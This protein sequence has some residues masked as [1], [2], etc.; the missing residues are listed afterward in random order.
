[1]LLRVVRRSIR[2]LCDCRSLL[3]ACVACVK[4]CVLN[5]QKIKNRELLTGL[6]AEL[7]EGVM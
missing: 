6:T 2:L 5:G 1:M 4:K 3:H 7:M